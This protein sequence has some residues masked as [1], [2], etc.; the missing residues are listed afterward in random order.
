MSNNVLRVLFPA[1]KGGIAV[2][3]VAVKTV[4]MFIA[5]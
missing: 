1:F 4:M 2:E 3:G 5:S